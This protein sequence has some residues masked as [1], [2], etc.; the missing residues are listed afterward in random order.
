[1]SRLRRSPFVVATA[2]L[3]ITVL[4]STSGGCSGQKNG[5]VGL[6]GSAADGG[7]DSSNTFAPED[8]AAVFQPGTPTSSCTTGLCLAVPANCAST[9]SLSGIVYDPAGQ[10]PIYGAV[11]FVPN[12]PNGNLP[13][14]KPGTNSCGT[15][16]ASVGNAVAVT[17]TDPGGH[18]KLT[19]VPATSHVPLV[20]QVGKWRRRNVF[21]SSVTACQD[22]PVPPDMSRLPRNQKEGDMPQMALLT[23]GCDDLGCFLK[24]VGIDASEFSSPRGGGRLDIYRGGD[25]S[26]LGGPPAPNLVGGRTGGAAGNCASSSCPL[27]SSTSNL[28][29]Y[30]IVLLACEC[31]ENQ[32]N[33]PDK[34]PL[35]DWVD[36]GGKVFTTHYQYTWFKN[37]PADFQKVAN[38]TTGADSPDAAPD[39]GP[40]RVD[41]SFPKGKALLDLLANRA[42]NANGTVP[43]NPPDVKTSVTTVNPPTVRWIYDVSETPNNVKYMSIDAPIGGIPGQMT[44]AGGPQYCGKAVFTDIHT[45]GSPQGDIPSTCA[46]APMTPQQKALEFLFFDL[47]AC[48][49]ADTAPPP[50]YTAR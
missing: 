25:D 31:T 6:G 9:T 23:G 50:M 40:F 20:V 42:L 29:Y 43:L 44:S 14:I 30:D 47:S 34:T 17:T 24:N 38:W 26:N 32:A 12:D 37:G 22:T 39:P 27:W 21:I 3:I 16:D 7:D 13:A 5:T 35:H 11:V 19:G 1:M 18:F 33:K 46:S 4:L 2:L 49:Q 8:A 36:K 28:E 45:S 15:C 48:V 10:N 41:T